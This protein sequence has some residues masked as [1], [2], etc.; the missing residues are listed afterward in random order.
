MSSAKKADDSLLSCGRCVRVVRADRARRAIITFV[1]E[2]AKTVD[3]LY[4]Q[5]KGNEK[6]EVEEEG[7]A[8]KLVQTLQDFELAVPGGG[9]E[10]SLF[11]SASASKEKGNQLFK[12]K[13][14]EAAAEFYSAAIAAFAGRP[15]ER[16][17]R[18][19][20]IER[21]AEQEQAPSSSSRAKPSASLVLA[22]VMSKDAESTCELSTGVEEQVEN[23][24][25]I[26]QE[27]LPLHTSVYMNRARCRQNLGLHK[28]AAQDLTA[29]LGL[30]KGVDKR[31][32]EADPEM[33]E[34]EAK[35]LYTAEYLRGRSRL[36]RGFARL[37]AQDVK[38][39]LARN[40][41]A[42]TV[43]QLRQLKTEVQAAQEK[44]R[45]VNGP[46]AKELAKVVIALRPTKIS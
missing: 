23:L 18:V 6:E 27:L 32:L 5:P 29:V 3:V 4:P 42:A 19:L 39:A 40:P 31:M 21:T 15:V 16:G 2:D 30:W 11:K 26:C 24:L 22:T 38:D 7:V 8:S 12:L 13:D 43:K 14:Y 33:K 41:P 35:G 37:A 17:E 44:Q 9:V 10:E 28:L 25:P 1:D 36:A 46:L 45:M 20:A 34:A